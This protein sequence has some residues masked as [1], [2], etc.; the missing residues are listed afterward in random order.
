VGLSHSGSK[1]IV[2]CTDFCTQPAAFSLWISACPRI[3][4]VTGGF[5]NSAVLK[6]V[7]QKGYW[8]VQMAWPDRHLHFFGKFLSQAEA[9]KWIEQHRWLTEHGQSSRDE[10]GRSGKLDPP[11]NR[12]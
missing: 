12:E 6:A 8:R 1:N 7:A 3:I 2:F 9:E 10:G 11:D 5:L 4:Y